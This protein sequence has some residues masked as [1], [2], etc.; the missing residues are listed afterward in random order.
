MD[1]L[2]IEPAIYGPASYE[3]RADERRVEEDADSI[4]TLRLTLPLLAALMPSDVEVT[5]AYDICENI[6]QDY[7]LASFDLVGITC[8]RHSGQM[9]RAVLLAETLSKLGVR[10]VVGG[11]VTVENN[12]HYVSVLSRSFDA[13]VIGD[14]EPQLPSLLEDARQDT[15]KKLY[16]EED[17]PRFEGIPVPRFDLVNLDLFTEPHVFPA[18]TARGCPRKCTFCSEFMYGS[19]RLRPVDEVIEELQVYKS[20]YGVEFIV[21]RDDDFLVYPKHSRELLTK[22]LPLGL[23]WTCQTDLH[24]TRHPDIAE[25][26]VDAGMRAV[27]FGLESIRESNRKD[28][29]KGFFTLAGVKELLHMLNGRGV[30]TQINIIFGLDHD[31]PDIFDD[32]VDFL[33]EHRIS[34]FYGNILSPEPGTTLY[35][36]LQV[37]GR[38]LDLP[39]LEVEEPANL[40]YVPKGLSPEELVNGTRSARD[41]FHAERSPDQNFW[42]GIEKTLY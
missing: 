3:Q 8:T 38:M 19:W 14:A 36:R 31:T 27:C 9:A 16:H 17:F 2:L 28:I 23:E 18:Q 25:L 12:H 13:V 10:S 26:A 11:P 41:R 22:M 34:T 39:P 15:L 4:S 20:R 40:N 35:E 1:V 7:D 33:L 42:L 6:Q 30:E 21:F 32:T 5:L 37:E 29:G 24:L